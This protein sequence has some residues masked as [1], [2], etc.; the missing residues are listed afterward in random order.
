MR[1]SSRVLCSLLSAALLS[2]LSACGTLLYP[3]RRGQLQ[4]QI[5]PVV[6]GMNA[7]GILFFVIPGLVAFGIDFASGAIY[8]PSGKYSVAPE[9]LKQTLDADGNP[10]PAQLKHLVHKATG[11]DLPIEQA[12]RVALPE[13][14]AALNEA[15]R[16]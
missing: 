11:M 8:L 9:A 14:L 15:P 10:D 16:A 12:Q 4:G 5:D 7:I 1:V 2:Q 3:E 6:A 13:Y